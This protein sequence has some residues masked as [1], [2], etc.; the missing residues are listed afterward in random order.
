MIR[1][2]LPAVLLLCLACSKPNEDKGVQRAFYFWQT[3]LNNFE[4]GDSAYQALHVNRVYLRMF[5][6]DWDEGTQMTTPVSPLQFQYAYWN[7]DTE[8]VP[9]VFITNRTFKQL[10]KEQSVELAHQV[11]RKVVTMMASLLNAHQVPYNEHYDSQSPYRVLSKD[12]R[13]Q[14]KYDSTYQANMTRVKQVQFD[15]DWTES[16]REKYFA[17]L[18]TCVKLFDQQLVSSTVRLYQYKYPGKAGVPPVKRGMLMCYNAGNI[19][20]PETKNSI[21]DVKEVKSYLEGSD[22]EI[23]L[24]YALPTFEWAVLFQQGKFASILSAEDLRA[25]YAD[26]LSEPQDGVSQVTQDF[27]YGSDYSGIYIRY[28]DEIRFETADLRDVQEIASWLSSH[29]NNKDAVL[30]LYHLNTY[31]LQKHSKEIESIFGSF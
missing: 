25:N 5:D 18:E 21:F 26:Y 2:L 19:K 4:W 17:F 1:Y 15:C 9:V 8:A 24:D 6:V 13:E 22:Y 29:K 14:A 28:G 20:D 3:S 31:D 23:P 30:T 12:F 11:H 10:T 16:T 7:K 27:V